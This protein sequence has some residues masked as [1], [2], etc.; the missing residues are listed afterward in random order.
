[1]TDT[2]ITCVVAKW[3]DLDNSCTLVANTI[4]GQDF[5]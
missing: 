1:M 3:V 5:F 4:G 2:T